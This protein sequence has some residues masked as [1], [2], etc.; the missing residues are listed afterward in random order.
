[1]RHD[2]VQDGLLLPHVKAQAQ[3][4]G[5]H[6]VTE[7]P[8]KQIGRDGGDQVEDIGCTVL[9]ADAQLLGLGRERLGQRKLVLLDGLGGAHAGISTVDTTSASKPNTSTTRTH[10]LRGPALSGACTTAWVT[11]RSGSPSLAVLPR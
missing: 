6:V 11:T 9:Q 10:T 5:D 3:A 4:A 7:P 8:A 2:G 1:M